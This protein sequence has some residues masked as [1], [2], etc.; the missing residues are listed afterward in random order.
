V[1]GLKRRGEPL[2]PQDV[3]VIAWLYGP[4][5]KEVGQRF[6]SRKRIMVY[7]SLEIATWALSLLR[8][9]HKTIQMR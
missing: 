2:Q 7:P 4:S 6:E 9:R 5:T 3:P 8:D 1:V